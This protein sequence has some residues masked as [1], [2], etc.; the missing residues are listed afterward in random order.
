MFVVCEGSGTDDLVW[1]VTACVIRA[2]GQQRAVGSL[3][4]TTSKSGWLRDM[5][6]SL[7]SR[8]TECAVK[9]YSCY[10][11]NAPMETKSKNG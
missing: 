9:T 1:R 3:A 10:H 11:I 4:A 6:V 5:Q 7:K 2:R 8:A